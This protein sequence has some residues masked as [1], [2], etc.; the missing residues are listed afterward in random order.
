[1]LLPRAFIPQH[2]ENKMWKKPTG[3]SRKLLAQHVTSSILRI[4]TAPGKPGKCLHVPYGDK[5]GVGLA[6]VQDG[7]G[8]SRWVSGCLSHQSD[9]QEKLPGQQGEEKGLL[10]MGSPRHH[11]SPGPQEIGSLCPVAKKSAVSGMKLMLWDVQVPAYAGPGIFYGGWRRA[12]VWS[13]VTD[14]K[15]S[16]ACHS[17]YWGYTCQCVICL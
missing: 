4:L 5:L 10:C 2:L 11:L 12:L 13:G 15:R 9:N 16:R 7:W 17:S 3:Y 8:C 14:F 1:M 6:Q